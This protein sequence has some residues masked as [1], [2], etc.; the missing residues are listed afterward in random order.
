M[1]FRQ[2]IKIP[3]FRKKIDLALHFATSH[4]SRK[5]NDT[6]HNSLDARCK[7]SN[8]PLKYSFPEQLPL[9]LP[10]NNFLDRS[11]K[12]DVAFISPSTPLCSN[13]MSHLMRFC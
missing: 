9:I 5:E 13:S 6:T 10:A 11:S 3:F 8:V 12:H 7:L 2:A 4:H 1:I